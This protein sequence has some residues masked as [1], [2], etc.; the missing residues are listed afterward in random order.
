MEKKETTTTRQHKIFAHLTRPGPIIFNVAFVLKINSFL[1]IKYVFT[2]RNANGQ[3]WPMM[4]RKYIGT[5]TD[6]SM[7]SNQEQ[8]ENF[9]QI[10][11]TKF[12][13]VINS[14]NIKDQRNFSR[15]RR[16]VLPMRQIYYCAF[17]SKQSFFFV[18]RTAAIVVTFFFPWFT[19][20]LCAHWTDY[21]R[22]ILCGKHVF[23]PMW[24]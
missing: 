19:L 1:S 2:A 5:I 14:V 21:F 15:E 6:S 22:L 17:C 16:R 8:I 11:A 9:H 13:P 3:K 24:M 12:T 18:A 10:D 23:V 20:N 7:L 4:N